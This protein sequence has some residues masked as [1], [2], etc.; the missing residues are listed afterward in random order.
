MA[1][2][3][4]GDM[5][6]EPGGP[7]ALVSD[8]ERMEGAKDDTAITTNAPD[9]IADSLGEYIRI[10]FRRVRSGESGV[11]PVVLGLIAIVAYFQIRSSLFL[12]AG[13]L[14]NLITQA[15]FIVTFGM[16]EVFVLLLGEIDLSVGYN[17]ALGAVVTLWILSGSH[18]PPWW[19]GVI[20]GLAF[21]AAFAGLEGIIITWLRLPSFVVT[22]AGYLGGFGLLLALIDTAAPGS[23]GTIRMNSTVLNA[24]EGGS[25]NPTASWIVMIAAVAATG[26]FMALRDINRRRHKLA[27]PPITVTVLKIAAI[28]VAGIVVVL[29]SNTN[30]GVGFFVVEGVPW[31]VLVILGLLVIWTILL[32][33]TRFGRY[34]YAIGGNAEAARRAGV[35]LSRI[36]IAAFMLCGLT[37][38]VSGIIY[39]SNLSGMSSNFQGGQYVLYAV[40]AAVIGGTS[41]FG[42]RGRMLGAVLGGLVVG[43]IYNGLQLLGL[44]PAA[45]NIWTAAV[46][47]AAVTVDALARRRSMTS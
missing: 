8:A 38:G 35:N 43:V 31:V 3:D 47:L 21:C 25:M 7:V 41:L 46:L 42:G 26:L 24:I 32:N 19:V 37:A 14:V 40:A 4:R 15:A 12:S 33:R 13:N 16:A 36:R 17:A 23:G 2:S 44:G 34:V 27:A 5:D 28:A 20:G 1:P 29:I 10:W 45:Q 30:R 11:L 39:S 18:P 9:L 6:Q 22:L